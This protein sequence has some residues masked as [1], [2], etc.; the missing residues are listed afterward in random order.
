MVRRYLLLSPGPTP[1]P[2]EVLLEGAKETIHH[3]TP[4]FVNL[5]KETLELTKYVFQTQHPVYVL[6]SSGTGGMETA[7]VNLVNPGKKR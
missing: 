4:E 5:L 7:M 2:Q 6:S 3:R 1:V